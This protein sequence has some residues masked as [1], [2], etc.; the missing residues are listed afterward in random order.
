MSIGSNSLLKHV[1]THYTMVGAEA[2]QVTSPSRQLSPLGNRGIKR[3]ELDRDENSSKQSRRNLFLLSPVVYETDDIE[4]APLPAKVNA[5]ITALNSDRKF[6]FSNNQGNTVSSRYLPPSKIEVG[7]DLQTQS[8]AH[9]IKFGKK[10]DGSDKAEHEKDVYNLIS[11]PNQG[12]DHKV[13]KGFCEKINKHI[14]VKGFIKAPS[15]NR[16]IALSDEASFRKLNE[17]KANHP[18]LAF[19]VAEIYS[20]PTEAGDFILEYVA[21]DEDLHEYTW[22][23]KGS[24]DKVPVKGRELIVKLGQ[25]LKTMWDNKVET[26]D[27][28]YTNVVIKNGTFVVIDATDYQKCTEKDL[29]IGMDK[30]IK[31]FSIG[32]PEVATYLR[33]VVYREEISSQDAAKFQKQLGYIKI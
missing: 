14:V 30:S 26:S 11:F 3:K 25:I 8:I 10:S 13:W 23:N 12:K 18:T 6:I 4:P 5:L 9:A 21:P 19:R 27:F 28:S 15:D 7:F 29:E 24:L 20:K 17:F 33:H 22:I 1:N 2:L 32:N 31:E 16:R